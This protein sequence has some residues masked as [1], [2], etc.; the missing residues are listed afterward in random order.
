MAFTFTD[1]NVNEIIESGKPVVIDFWTTPCSPK[2]DNYGQVGAHYLVKV[3]IVKFNCHS[4]NVL[5]KLCG[6]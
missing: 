5:K 3:L 4:C 1:E 2:V 6:Y